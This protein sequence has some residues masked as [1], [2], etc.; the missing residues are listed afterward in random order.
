MRDSTLVFFVTLHLKPECIDE[1]RT[2]LDELLRDMQREPAFVSCHL[3]RD[4]Q[5]PTRFTLYEH[6]NEVS[7]EAFLAHQATDYRDRYETLLPRWLQSP[8]QAQVLLPLQR[9]TAAG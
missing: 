3:D 2:A 1:W 5:D 9:W 7:V 4:A 6:W 8:R